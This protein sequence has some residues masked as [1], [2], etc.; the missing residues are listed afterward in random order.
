MKRRR[1]TFMLLTAS[2]I[3]LFAIDMAVGASGIS[4]EEVIS[5]LC[6]QSASPAVEKIILHIRLPKA[7]VALLAG[8][9]LSV[10]GLQMQTLFRNPLAGPY[11]LGISS[12]AS[13]GNGDNR[14]TAFQLR[15]HNTGTRH[16]R[17]RMAR[18]GGSTSAHKRRIAPHTRYNGHSDSWHDALFRRGRSRTDS[19]IP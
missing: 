8:I 12:G 9:A 11:V 3:L 1:L 13:L 7:I 4:P 17:R 16:R 14:R 5:A 15:R 10:S 2:I 6:G 19:S 18:L